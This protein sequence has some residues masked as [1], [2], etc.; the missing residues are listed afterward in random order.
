M[1][2]INEWKTFKIIVHETLGY[3]ILNCKKRNQIFKAYASQKYTMMKNDSYFY[4][5]RDIQNVQIMTENSLLNHLII[6]FESS[7]FIRM[8]LR[9]CWQNK[10]L[11]VLNNTTHQKFKQEIE[12]RRY[13]NSNNKILQ[14]KLGIS[15]NDLSN[16]QFKERNVE[17]VLDEEEEEAAARGNNK[18]N[19]YRCI[20]NIDRGFSLQQKNIYKYKEYFIKQIQSLELLCFSYES[21]VFDD[22]CFFII[23]VKHQSILG[24][25]SFLDCNKVSVKT[26]YLDDDKGTILYQRII[27]DDYTK[28]QPFILEYEFST[29]ENIC[30]HNYRR[31]CSIC[32]INKKSI[33]KYFDIS[34]L[35]DAKLPKNKNLTNGYANLST[36][37]LVMQQRQ[38][39]IPAKNIFYK[40]DGVLACLKFYNN[41]FV[42]STNNE[43][44]SYIHSLPKKIIHRLID[45]SF[46][47][48]SNL[49]ES[50]FATYQKPKPMAIIDFHNLSFKAN[51]RMNIIHCLKKLMANDLQHYF[52]FFQGEE[53]LRNNN[54]VRELEFYNP[55]IYKFNRSIRDYLQFNFKFFVKESNNNNNNNNNNNKISLRHGKIYEVIINNKYEIISII[56]PRPDKL[57]PNS[58]KYIESIINNNAASI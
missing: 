49:Y 30:R 39:R 44:Q 35:L 2:I 9:Q 8:T 3:M 22:S 12:C 4:I 26:T 17:I 18:N 29:L 43:S 16:L 53:K 34:C 50:M 41:H 58:R 23:D 40:L 27:L 7:F 42:V 14:Q 33:E 57:Y 15:C 1:E 38:K 31:L 45:F 48:E 52:I 46:I 10:Y 6:G 28:E 19:R 20:I 21:P 37:P 56:K 5:A 25:A 13:I 54:N 55:N 32:C 47:V 36:K 24:L 11:V 51:R